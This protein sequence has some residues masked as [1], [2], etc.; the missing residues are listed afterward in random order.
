MFFSM[1]RAV[2]LYYNS[3][4]VY[5][6]RFW[7]CIFWIFFLSILFAIFLGSCIFKFF[8]CVYLVT[9]RR[10]FVHCLLRVKGKLGI[11]QSVGNIETGLMSKKSRPVSCANLRA[12]GG[13]GYFPEGFH[14]GLTSN[15]KKWG[16]CNIFPPHHSN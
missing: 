16:R 9:W 3:S 2:P 15:W 14:S 8:Q 10:L 7:G 1:C 4:E 5:F 13:K 12:G 6:R 11:A